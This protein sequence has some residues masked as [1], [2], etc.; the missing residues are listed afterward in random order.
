MDR[1]HYHDPIA[2]FVTPA[3][4]IGTLC[5]GVYG[6]RVGPAMPPGSEFYL[7]AL[8]LRRRPSH[9][10]P[11]I[12]VL[13]LF[14]GVVYLVPCR[15]PPGAQPQRRVRFRALTST[16]WTG[17]NVLGGLAGLFRVE[18]RTCV[19]DLPNKGPTKWYVPN[20]NGYCYLAHVPVHVSEVVRVVEIVVS[21]QDGCDDLRYRYY[22]QYR[23]R[24]EDLNG[25]R[26]SMIYTH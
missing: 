21:V 5:F 6:R 25:D 3:S 22:D 4:R 12:V 14:L 7:A 17:S 16:E 15:L 26:S 10:L 24:N 19:E 20:A 8:R 13:V 18:P 23:I 9:P 2:R 1:L 11:V